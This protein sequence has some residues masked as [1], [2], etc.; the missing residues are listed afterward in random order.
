MPDDGDEVFPVVG[1][2]N[3]TGKGV[4][5]GLGGG[6]K[7]LDEEDDVTARLRGE[8]IMNLSA[9]D[10]LS[11]VFVVDTGLPILLVLLVLSPKPAPLCPVP[12]P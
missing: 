7:A 3:G 11:L 5:C 2:G 10:A 12:N 9:T 1:N 6:I 4:N 8:G